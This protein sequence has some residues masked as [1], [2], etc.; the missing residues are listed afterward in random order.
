MFFNKNR[1]MSVLF[2]EK[3]LPA[4][5]KIEKQYGVIG[6]GAYGRPGRHP[7]G[8]YQKCQC[9]KKKTECKRKY[10]SG[11]KIFFCKGL[12]DPHHGKQTVPGS[13]DTE[14]ESADNI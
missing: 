3:I 14:K 2:L 8:E 12:A 7:G 13:E 1:K 5:G 9:K 4:F 6:E 11:G 10:S